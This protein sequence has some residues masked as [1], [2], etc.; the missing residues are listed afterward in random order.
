M[1]VLRVHG[2]LLV[3]N[4]GFSS[5]EGAVRAASC[6]R[7]SWCW[8]TLSGRGGAGVLEGLP[9]DPSTQVLGFWVSSQHLGP[10][11]QASSFQQFPAGLG[12]GW[13]SAALI[14]PQVLL[15]GLPRSYF[16]PCCQ[17]PSHSLPLP[18]TPLPRS[19][20][21][22]SSTPPFPLL[23][24]EPGSL[25]NSGEEWGTLWASLTLLGALCPASADPAPQA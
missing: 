22:A 9:L 19:L 14:R 20:G 12:L 6:P 3:T 5:P 1:T 15:P 21:L 7:W 11:G 24:L 25:W 10:R 8:V 2:W 16:S 23:P 17:H 4:K 18:L 13:G